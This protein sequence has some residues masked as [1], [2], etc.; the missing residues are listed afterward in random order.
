MFNSEIKLRSS[1]A[2]M[3]PPDCS[4]I[5]LAEWEAQ[6]N[7]ETQK[8]PQVQPVPAESTS[9]STSQN[10]TFTQQVTMMPVQV[11][12]SLFVIMG[13]LLFYCYSNYVQYISFT[14]LVTVL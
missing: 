3:F 7:T 10:E 6:K 8:E 4:V 1:C 12:T 14:Q 13:S 5:A 9:A 11:Q 2:E